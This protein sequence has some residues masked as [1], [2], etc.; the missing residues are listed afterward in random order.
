MLKFKLLNLCPCPA[1][2]VGSS[3]C[4]TGASQKFLPF[5]KNIRIMDMSLY[6]EATPSLSFPNRVFQ[7]NGKAPFSR[8]GCRAVLYTSVPAGGVFRLNR[9]VRTA[10]QPRESKTAGVWRGPN[11]V[12][13]GCLAPLTPLRRGPCSVSWSERTG[14]CATQRYHLTAELFVGSRAC[15]MSGTR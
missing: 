3:H 7:Q 9:A 2:I 6:G 4:A 15:T 1:I 5:G 11:L 8:G 14:C 12:S 10:R 13:R